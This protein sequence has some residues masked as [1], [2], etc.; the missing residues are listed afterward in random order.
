MGDNARDIREEIAETRERLAETAGA[1]AYKADVPSRVKDSIGETTSKAKDRITGVF[2][3]ASSSVGSA[4]SRVGDAAT[5]AGGQMSHRMSSGMSTTAQK[6]RENPT[7]AFIGGIAAGLVLGL[8]VPKTRFEEER[9]GEPAANL[10]NQA[11][12]RVAEVGHRAM[13]K[14]KEMVERVGDRATDAVANAG[15]TSGTSDAP[16][17]AS[18]SAG[19]SSSGGSTSTPSVG[20]PY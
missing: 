4:A 6:A 8:L 17:A 19:S 5:N 3:G 10:V 2:G 18:T 16:S 15:S 9:L 12:E 1:V 14:E 20:T 7:G 13:E 11:T